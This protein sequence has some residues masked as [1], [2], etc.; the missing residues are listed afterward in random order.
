MCD[1][2]RA[3][4]FDGMTRTGLIAQVA[5]ALGLLLSYTVLTA[6]NHDATALLA[7]LAG[8]GAGAGIAQAGKALAPAGE[9]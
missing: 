2:A 3:R 1:A 8:Q 6:L 5:L 7:L 9:G 4:I